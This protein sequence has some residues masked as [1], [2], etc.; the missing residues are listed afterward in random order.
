MV[1][2]S[3]YGFY[4][5]IFKE[6]LIKTGRSCFDQRFLQIVI[7]GVLQNDRDNDREHKSGDD[8][9]RHAS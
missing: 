9:A 5:F 1:L 6:P 7:D 4:Q 3:W 2:S 8:R